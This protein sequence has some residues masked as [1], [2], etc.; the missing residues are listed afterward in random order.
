M[1]S[2]IARPSNPTAWAA[3]WFALAGLVL[4]P[5]P[6]FIGL[7]LGGGLSV[8]AAILAVIALFK[9]IARNGKGIAPV[10]FAGIFIAITWA[11]ISVGG[12]TIW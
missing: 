3:F 8:I 6:L 11:G 12:G 4:M 9:G 2:F 1:S 10:V 5:I 7:I